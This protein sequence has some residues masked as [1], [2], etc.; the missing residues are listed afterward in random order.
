MT[1]FPE[2]K[3]PG[4]AEKAGYD[5]LRKALPPLCL[6]LL[7]VLGP[8]RVSAAAGSPPPIHVTGNL[9]RPTYH[10]EYSTEQIESMSGLR[11]P[12]RAAH[13]PGLTLF[14]YEISSQYE[15]S[16]KGRSPNEALLIWAKSI[17]VNFSITRME[18]FVSNKYA[19]GSCQYRTILA[20]ENTHVAINERAYKK[21]KALLI[22]A[23][24]RDRFLP[25]QARPLRVASEKEGEEILDRHLKGILTPL[26]DRFRTE[27]KR[28]NAKID[29][30]A[31]YARTQAKCG[32]W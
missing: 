4:R 1:V 16:E 9:L 30:P 26:E 2:K 28:E 13:E 14:E 8:Q 18:V 3:G 23:L 32:D 10:H 15:M 27:D 24:K 12:S 25:T 29:T 6:A 22:Q 17:D 31:S 19:E 20:H 5:R 7:G 11:A 21:Y